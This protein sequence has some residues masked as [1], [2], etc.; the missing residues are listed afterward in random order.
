MKTI[1]LIQE[2]QP[3]TEPKKEIKIEPKKETKKIKE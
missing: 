1:G 2:A 3:K